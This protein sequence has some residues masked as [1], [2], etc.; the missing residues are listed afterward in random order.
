[1]FAR[2]TAALLMITSMLHYPLTTNAQNNISVDSYRGVS[3]KV[4][5]YVMNHMDIAKNSDGSTYTVHFFGERNLKYRNA[6]LV[7]KKIKIDDK[8]SILTITF[9][10]NKAVIENPRS[11]KDKAI[12]EKLKK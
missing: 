9:D 7:N 3:G 6:I 5:I 11:K 12:F 10:K 1:M 8:G 2:T 4:G